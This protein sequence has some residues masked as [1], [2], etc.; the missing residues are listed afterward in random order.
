MG[1]MGSLRLLS[2]TTADARP[3]IVLA[4]AQLGKHIPEAN[5]QCL[6]DYAESSGQKIAWPPDVYY[7][8]N[9]IPRQGQDHVIKPNASVINLWTK[10]ICR[11][12]PL[13]YLLLF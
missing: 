13:N 6:P 9:E 5:T 12:L 3:F 8:S 2:A 4:E 10:I 7:K 11:G 1:Q